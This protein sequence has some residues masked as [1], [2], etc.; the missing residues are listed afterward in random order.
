MYTASD[1][2][3]SLVEEK[4]VGTDE[5]THYPVCRVKANINKDR[6]YRCVLSGDECIDELENFLSF[7]KSIS[8]PRCY[9]SD[10]PVGMCYNDESSFCAVSNS[11][12]SSAF[13]FMT[14]FQLSHMDSPPK[15][16]RLCQTTTKDLTDDMEQSIVETGRCVFADGEYGPCVMESTDCNDNETFKSSAQLRDDNI[17]RCHTDHFSGG[18]CLGED[19]GE[20]YCTNYKDACATPSAFVKRHSCT[21][22][23]DMRTENDE[24]M[25]FGA[26]K[27]IQ[28]KHRCV[29]HSSECDNLEEYWIPAY[30]PTDWYDGCK[31]EDVETG[32]CDDNGKYYCA[33]SSNACA[34]GHTYIPSSKTKERGVDCRL[35]ETSRIS[36]VNNPAKSPTTLIPEKD[37][38]N[39]P[40]SSSTK[41][42]T[43]APTDKGETNP[44]TTHVVKTSTTSPTENPTPANNILLPL[45]PAAIKDKFDDNIGGNKID[46]GIDND[47]NNST[48]DDYDD[49]Y[50]HD[51]DN[52]NSRLDTIIIIYG[53]II[54]TVLFAIT[55]FV[56]YYRRP[57]P[58]KLNLS[59]NAD[60]MTGE[61]V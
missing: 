3:C 59:E 25:F 20:V 32:A 2:S 19:D 51:E 14:A 12:C 31:C 8:F 52:S 57:S 41:R 37:E 48:N 9:C 42:A 28:Q 54:G 34:V 40:T 53:S 47:I 56:S 43:N 36:P 17:M 22:F 33:V 15:I 1:P 10:V 44:T 16:C 7:D 29:W 24:P 13:E 45:T 18:E 4:S 38:T 11:D 23:S 58:P 21:I 27:R 61:V 60:I 35:C 46:K 50:F 49:F 55:A 39:P 5:K 26:C 6:P 30:T